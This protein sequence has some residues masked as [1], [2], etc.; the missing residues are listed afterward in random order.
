MVVNLR[1]YTTILLPDAM[2]AVSISIMAARWSLGVHMLVGIHQPH[3]L[4]WL[5]Y[6]EK[7]DACD[8][9][10]LLDT[11]QF[12]KNGWQNRN[13]IKTAQG[14][15]VLTVPVHANSDTTIAEVAI[16]TQRRWQRRHQRAIEQNYKRAPYFEWTMD[17][18][19]AFYLRP[20]ESL[21]ELNRE[22]LWAWMDL[23]GIDTPIHV[24]SELNVDGT[25]TERLV[26]LV[27]AVG[28]DA[29]YSGAHALD[30]YLDAQVVTNAGI[31]LQLQQWT[32]PEYP[33]LHREFIPDLSILDLVMNVGP[34]ALA[35]IRSGGGRRE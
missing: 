17:T 8:V 31:G 5:R 9:F 10:I 3:Y 35:V 26:N 25:A 7:I 16:D 19:D 4:P 33:Q 28:G 15:L 22:M 32:A 6:F 18:I 12:T 20:F 30:V 13:K 24:A 27:R 21:A 2:A 11:V 23:L 14:D 29:Y 1:N 34:D